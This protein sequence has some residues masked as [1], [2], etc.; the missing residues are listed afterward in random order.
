MDVVET[1]QKAPLVSVI[2]PVYNA[3]RFLEAAVSSVLNQTMTDWELLMIDDG[4]KDNSCE[5]AEAFARKD[6]RIRFL[7]NA[8]NMGVSKTRNRGIDLAQGSF[9]A[10]LDSD[11]RWHPRKLE[12]QLAAMEA[13]KAD[14]CYTSYAIVD[15]KG[16]P[17][18]APYI[19]PHRIDFAGLLKENAMGCSTVILRRELLG[20]HR[21]GEAYYHEDYVLWLTLLREGVRACGCTEILT[22]WRLIANSRSFNKFRSAAFRWKIY[23]GYLQLPLCKSLWAFSCYAAASLRKYR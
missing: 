9:V 17:S 11:D 12:A 21:F 18:K 13:E 1:N 16:N 4:S 22:D 15:E 6:P 7:K 3:A 10:F 19:V 5:I 14:L 2:M 20:E 23:R 8:Q